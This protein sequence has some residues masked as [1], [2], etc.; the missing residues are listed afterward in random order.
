MSVLIV[1]SSR[2]AA[3]V[4]QSTKTKRIIDLGVTSGNLS[5]ET[6]AAAAAA[7]SGVHTL[8][9]DS[10]QRRALAN[11]PSVNYSDRSLAIALLLMLCSR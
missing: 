9:S 7:A 2:V 3:G 11:G 6:A 10:A 4:L 8:L 5:C 1:S